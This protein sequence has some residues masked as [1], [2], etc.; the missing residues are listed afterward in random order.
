MPLLA[1]RWAEQAEAATAVA[2]AMGQ[3]IEIAATTAQSPPSRTPDR[4]V[5][6]RRSSHI[7]PRGERCHGPQRISGERGSLARESAKADFGQSLPRFQSPPGTRPAWPYR[8]KLSVDDTAARQPRSS[9][10]A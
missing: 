3:A 1:V 8:K 4:Q 9:R 7:V 6:T 10:R 5:L 2:M